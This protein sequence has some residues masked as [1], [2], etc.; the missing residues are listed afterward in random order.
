M[1]KVEQ[2]KK[3]YPNEWL[4]LK[5][6]KE[7]QDGSIY[8]KLIFHHSDR[9]FLHEVLRRKKV[10]GAYITYAGPLVKSGYAIMF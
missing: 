3:K 5:V 2:L 1:V 6:E 10:K 4:A 9:R 8:A 7:E